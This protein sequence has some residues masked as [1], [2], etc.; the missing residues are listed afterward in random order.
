MI[1]EQIMTMKVLRDVTRM[2][3]DVRTTF[4]LM[5]LYA[6]HLRIYNASLMPKQHRDA[7]IIH[8]CKTA[9]HNNNCTK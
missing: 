7:K 6:A 4:V 9:R 2:C 3:V 5:R 1:Y 8:E